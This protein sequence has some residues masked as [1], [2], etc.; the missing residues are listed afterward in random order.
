M[1][2]TPTLMDAKTDIFRCIT[3]SYSK[4]GINDEN[5]KYF[6]N[7]ALSTLEKLNLDQRKKKI[8]EKQISKTKET[9]KD[10]KKIREDLLLIV[11]L[12]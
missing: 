2:Y 1:S 12:L 3:S 8:V 4:K 10:I 5:Y 6:L 11:S 9:K 7:S